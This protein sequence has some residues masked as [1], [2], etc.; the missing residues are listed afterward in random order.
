MAS[1]SCANWVK[2]RSVE[3]HPSIHFSTS[4]IFLYNFCFCLFLKLQMIHKPVGQTTVQ[5]SCCVLSI[6]SMVVYSV[7]HQRSCTR[8]YNN[9]RVLGITTVV[10]HSVLQQW[11]CTWYYVNGHG[12][13]ITTVI[14]HLVLR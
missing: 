10:M 6:T 3:G 4:N 5:K 8:Y 13:G 12:L 2:I 11:S 1:G 7:L 14:V 9:G